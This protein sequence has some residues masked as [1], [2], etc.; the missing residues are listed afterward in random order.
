LFKVLLHPVQG[1]FKCA[2]GRLNSDQS[3]VK[4]GA[5]NIKLNSFSLK[6]G[7]GKNFLHPGKH[8]MNC[9]TLSFYF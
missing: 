7:M 3:T 8:A 6:P 4:S 5:G 1:S 9:R 2:T